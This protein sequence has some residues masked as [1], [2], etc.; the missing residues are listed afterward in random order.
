MDDFQLL[1]KYE[2]VL[3]FAKSERFFPIAVEPYLEECQLFFSGA[4][5]MEESFER[6]NEP[7]LE[8]IGELESPQF[9]LRFVNRFLHSADVWVYGGVGAAI[10]T[11]AAWLLF[12]ALGAEIA[13]GASL[14]V[15]LIVFMLA[16]PI[17]LRVIPA[18]AFFLSALTLSLAP[19]YYVFL[20]ETPKI[21]LAVK[22]FI[23]FP[24]YCA[25]LFYVLTYLLRFMINRILPEGPG[26]LL[27]VF[28][29]ATEKVA[30]EA[31]E[32]YAKILRKHKQ[33]TYYGRVVRQTAGEDRYVFL[34]YHYFYAF[35]DWRLAA[36]GFNHHEGD[37]EL[38]TV[39]LKN[40]APHSL[41]LSQHRTG[42]LTAW[43]DAVRALDEN[44]ERSD[45][46]V[47]YVS[48]GSHAHYGK[49][50]AILLPELYQPGSVQRFLFA[51]DNLIYYF[52]LLFNPSQKKR[53]SAMKGIRVNA[54]NLFDKYE[55]SDLEDEDDQY[56]VRLPMEIATGDGFRAG[57]Q[58]RNSAEPALPS[59]NYLKQSLAD[60]R[61]S[62]PP[63]QL[64]KCV[65]LNSET[66]WVQ[67]KGL[68]GVKNFLG[69][70]SGPPG[71]KWERP[72]DNG[73]AEERLR[74][75]DPLAWMTSLQKTNNNAQ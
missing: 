2:P 3:R 22:Y 25:L 15:W 31:A 9:Y 8:K 65:L 61:T 38:V 75:S 62:R 57:F 67:Y 63:I 35:N 69:D 29:Q 53:Q 5:G 40:D 23:F 37:W 32:L 7:L 72:K 16:S 17:R 24:L 50:K 43:E 70:E 27:D 52:F 10:A 26:F 51:L 73:D 18:T 54:Q 39:C 71:P 49:P 42:S 46:P 14:W 60:R 6:A 1:K 47:V 45:H 58:G 55:I 21:H 59:D 48:L 33:P 66:G 56:D 13:V 36:N 64:W 74:W 30:E 19:T 41:I 20:R 28:S 68:W 4:E 12:G 44:G 34:Q 11:F